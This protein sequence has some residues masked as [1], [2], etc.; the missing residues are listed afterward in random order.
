MTMEEWQPIDFEAAEI[1]SG[2]GGVKTLTVRGNAPGETANE[3]EVKLLPATYIAQPEYWRIE[4]FCNYKDTSFTAQIPYKV[5]MKLDIIY[6]SRGVEVC[7][8]NNSVKIDL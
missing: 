6:G 7:G 4:V 3:I 8:K 5:S 1:K 2:E